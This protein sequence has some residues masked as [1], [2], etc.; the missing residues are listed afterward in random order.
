L[1]K[2][3]LK[4]GVVSFSHAPDYNSSKDREEYVKN[5]YNDLCSCLEKEGFDLI[6]PLLSLREAENY[7]RFGISSNEDLKY[8]ILDLKK[9]EVDCLIIQI[10]Q[11]TRIPLAT[12][13]IKA[14]DIPTAIVA[15]TDN[16]YAG[17]ATATAITGSILESGFSKNSML[18]ERFQDCEIDSIVQW[19]K[20]AGTLQLMKRSRVLSFGGSYGADIPYT[21]DDEFSLENKFI[22]EIISEQEITI[23]EKARKILKNQAQRVDLFLKWLTNNEVEI[24][25]DN[26]MLSEESLKFQIAQYLAVKDRLRELANEDILGISVKCHFEVST[27]SIG[28]TECIIPGFLPFNSDSEGKKEI[29][30][31]ACEGDIKGLLTLVMLNILNP[32]VPPLFGDMIKYKKDYVIMSNCGSSSVYW[33]ARSEDVKSNLAKVSLKPQVHGKSGCAVHYKTPQGEATFARLFR[34][35]GIY[36]MHL[37]KINILDP[38]QVSDKITLPWPQTYF[39]FNADHN[40]FFKTSPCNH[41]CITEGDLIKEIEIFCKYA[42]IRIV[43]S[44]SNESMYAFLEEISCL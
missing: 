30:P 23:I 7:M 17:E 21:R 29:M 40:L 39:Q 36:Y 27:S 19:L 9:N 10:S 11:W 42:G 25:Y 3:K 38:D 20:G 6:K 37:G 13:L 31:V 26:K 14:L 8:C 33:A 43:R 12:D 24:S 44:D 28:C 5:D 2:R 35:K 1:S 4:I 34:V 41:G 16:Q 18:T 22:K 32:L 15:D